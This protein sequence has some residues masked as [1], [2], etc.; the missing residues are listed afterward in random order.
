MQVTSMLSAGYL[1]PERRPQAAAQVQQD[2]QA[3]EFQDIKSKVASGS[4]AGAVKNTDESAALS[5]QEDDVLS[6]EQSLRAKAGSAE[7]HTVYHYTLGADGRRYI[8]GASVTLKGD[9]Q[10]LNR[11][12]GGVTSKDVKAQARDDESSRKVDSAEDKSGSR[13]S[14]GAD[15]GSG[16]GLSK[17]EEAQVRELRQIDREV[18]NHEAAHQ[19]AAGALGGGASFS[20]TQG[21]DGKSYATGGEVPIQI[22][23]GS[24]P[25]ETLRNMQQVQR[26]ANAP[27][28]PSGQDR[29]VAARAASIAA[30]A[31]QEIAAERTENTKNAG[32]G[33]E[34]EKVSEVARG[35][36]L[37]RAI[38]R[39]ENEERERLDPSKNGVA[40][41]LASIRESQI[42]NMLMPA[43]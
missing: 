23:Q 31:M 35:T 21:P 33:D 4:N 18:R 40:S 37:L 10:D 19:A 5:R 16:S 22:K 12:G 17:E 1:Q 25:E 38:E 26:A 42:Q 41:L 39:K 9:E 24:T 36:P 43:A 29:S 14:E 11:V 8:T 20:Y 27:A 2:A 13:S 6:Q 3:A 32:A 34:R 28:D 15:A 30:Q 7:V